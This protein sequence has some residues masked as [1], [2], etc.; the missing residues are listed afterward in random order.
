M[1]KTHTRPLNGDTELGQV[2]NVPIFVPAAYS[3]QWDIHKHILDVRVV[4]NEGETFKN[5][6][7]DM[8]IFKSPTKRGGNP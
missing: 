4:P 7:C 5:F 6:L 8:I 1:H 3:L 2:K